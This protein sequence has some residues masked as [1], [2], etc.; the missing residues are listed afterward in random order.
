MWREISRE[1]P[2][3]GSTAAKMLLSVRLDRVSSSRV[4][5]MAWTAETL[6][7]DVMGVGRAALDVVSFSF[8]AGGTR[9]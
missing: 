9:I 4:G 6:P 8:E 3:Y 1:V 5:E 2:V 7:D